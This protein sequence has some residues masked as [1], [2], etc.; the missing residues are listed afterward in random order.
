MWARYLTDAGYHCWATGRFDLNSDVPTGFHEVETRN[1][2]FDNPDITSLFRNPLCYRMDER[3]DVDGRPRDERHHDEQLT[4]HTL[5]YLEHEAPSLGKPWLCWLGM[6]QPHPRFVALRQYYEMYPLEDIDLPEVPQ[7]DLEHLHLV[8]QAMRHY[9]RIATPIPEDRIRKAR[10]GYYGMITELDEYV[11]RVRDKLEETGQLENTIFIYTSDHGESLGEHGLWHKSSFYE[12]ASHVPFVMAGPGIP[13]GHVDLAAALYEWPGL[14]VPGEIRGHSLVPLLDGG[15]GDHPGWTYTESH[16]EG[17]MTGGFMIRKGPW[18]Y[19]HFQW[20]D[21]LLFNLDEDP[22]EF[23][24]RI[25]DPACGEV[26]RELKGILESQ[27]DTERVTLDAFDAQKKML[28]QLTEGKTEE[29]FAAILESRLGPGQ[30][31]LMAA[32]Q[33]RNP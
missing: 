21:G 20:H 23:E 26:V 25:E 31:R 12:N 7:K 6:S 13:Q 9:K 17:M 30:S 8:Y 33:P 14:E 2:H 1:G 15:T 19:V 24:N 28:G 10:A 5:S 32:T 29:E 22:G 11:G 27:V 4:N 18:K 3:P 16:S